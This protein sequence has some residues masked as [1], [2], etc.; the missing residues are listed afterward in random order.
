[1]W[2]KREGRNAARGKMIKATEGMK[3][4]FHFGTTAFVTEEAD[5]KGKG[6]Q[7]GEK[8]RG[9]KKQISG[10]QDGLVASQR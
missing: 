10:G 5:W 2:G 6:S 7:P 3:T 9:G 4:P 1:V 8:K